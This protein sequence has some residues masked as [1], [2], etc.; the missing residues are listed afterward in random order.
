MQSCDAREMHAS[1]AMLAAGWLGSSPVACCNGM[2]VG[3]KVTSRDEPP[4]SRVPTVLRP[5]SAALPAA[6][7]E[8]SEA[9]SPRLASGLPCT[10]TGAGCADGAKKPAHAF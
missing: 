10:M 5:M 1:C 7:A 6:V 8:P 2:P 9:A 3:M 4:R